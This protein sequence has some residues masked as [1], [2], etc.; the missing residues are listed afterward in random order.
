MKYQADP[1]PP[2][3]GVKVCSRCKVEK[4]I[5]EFSNDKTF[6]TGLYSHCKDC[7]K[8]A[9]R[10]R[11]IEIL[12][13]Y[14]GG[15]PACG[16]CGETELDFLTI[17]HVNDDGAAHRKELGGAGTTVYNW[18]IRNN[19][20][21]GFAVLCWNCNCARWRF[22]TCPHQRARDKASAPRAGDE[23]T[24]PVAVLSPSS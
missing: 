17:D 20:P 21:A 6:K 15:N 8:K 7:C 18:I 2:A 5:S 10:D 12:T 14:S 11:K 22:G 4:P 1:K 16:C 13:H 9:N 19:F 3:S 23:S 24:A